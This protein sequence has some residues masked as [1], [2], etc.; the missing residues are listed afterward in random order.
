MRTEWKRNVLFHERRGAS[1]ASKTRRGWVGRGRI[2]CRNAHFDMIATTVQMRM[3]VCVCVIFWQYRDFRRD[4]SKWTS[5]GTVPHTTTDSLLSSGGG[6]RGLASITDRLDLLSLS[7]SLSFSAES[8]AQNQ[9]RADCS[10]LPWWRRRSAHE[11]ADWQA[12][13]RNKALSLF[14]FLSFS[15]S[16]TENWWRVCRT[17]VLHALHVYR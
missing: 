16:W 6:W 11:M 9:C 7:L 13:A 4:A 15:E 2:A 17:E 14:L 3:C 1:P 12:P 5:S 10:G 8:V